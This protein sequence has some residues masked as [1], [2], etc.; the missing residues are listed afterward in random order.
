MVVP[1]VGKM[2]RPIGE[3]LA[4]AEAPE[5]IPAI[6]SDA[7]NP[8]NAWAVCIPLPRAI[9]KQVETACEQLRCELAMA[10][11]QL[12][13][14]LTTALQQAPHAVPMMAG[15]KLQLP[16]M[17]NKLVRT[18]PEVRPRVYDSLRALKSSGFDEASLAVIGKALE[19]AAVVPRPP[20]PPLPPSASTVPALGGMIQLPPPRPFPIVGP[21]VTMAPVHLQHMPPPSL[22]PLMPVSKGTLSEENIPLGSWAQLARLARSAGEA[23]SYGTIDLSS[24]SAAQAMRVPPIEGGRIEARLQEFLRRAHGLQQESTEKEVQGH[25][26]Y[27]AR[28]HERGQGHEESDEEEED[29]D[30]GIDARKG[31]RSRYERKH[32]LEDRSRYTAHAFDRYTEDRDLT[33][34]GRAAAA[35]AGIGGPGIGIGSTQSGRPGLGT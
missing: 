11:L 7:L 17:L 1:L 33:A 21:H 27:L 10:Q 26:T 5:I 16:Y 18:F 30:D 19:P 29:E 23:G 34:A 12:V 9:R 24:A 4:A 3:R 6:I 15:L 32:I 22:A 31:K 2:S 25:E 20:S 35:S 14:G 13:V 8:S 28:Q